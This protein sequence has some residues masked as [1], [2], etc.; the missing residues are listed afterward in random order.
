M[1]SSGQAAWVKYYQG[2]G[3]QAST[4][5]IAGPVYDE[6]TMM[7][8]GTQLAAGTPVL[9]LATKE[10]ESKPRIRVTIGGT[11]QTVRFKFDSITKPG[12]K[13][14]AASSLKPQAFNVVTSTPIQFAEYKKRLLAALDERTD[15]DGPLKG[16]LTEIVHYWSG[17]YS[18]KTKAGKIYMR[19][20]N[21]IPINDINKDFGEVLGPL[22]VMKHNLLSGT[23]HDKDVNA[24]SGIFI[25]A[26]PNEP[27][28]DY[29]V[30]NV[31]ISAKS[32]ETTNT[33]KGK[34][35]LDL[36]AKRPAMNTKYSDTK[37][38]QVLAMLTANSTLTGPINA[39][40]FVMG[41]KKFNAW[42]ANNTYFKSKKG[43]YTDNELMYECEKYLQNESKTGSLN[44]TKLFAD[45]IK[46]QVVYVKYQL[47]DTGVGKFE[48]IVS[49]DV[50]KSNQ[51]KRPYLRSKNGYT[52]AS[53]KMGIQI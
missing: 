19:I 5:K 18:A 30:G 43:K 49:A 3:D 4:V 9:V 34:D 45:A 24:T 29:K 14:S 37:E 10:Y 22:A 50:A 52:R 2:K 42:V 48:T 32:G 12:N 11:V 1:A 47:D 41:T 53:D 7:A 31:V 44:F 27:L 51:G 26:R 8:T 21:D 16:Y 46:G 25:P 20:R 6:K 36:L 13:A 17:D 23:G 15:L 35:I 38:Y 40:Q 33:V 39:A 28:M